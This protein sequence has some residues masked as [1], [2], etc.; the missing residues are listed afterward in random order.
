MTGRIEVNGEARPLAADNI[1]ALL[2]AERIDPRARGLAVALNGAVVP[3]RRWPETA[4][5]NGDRIEIVKP[6]AGG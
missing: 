4:I 5:S 6:F 3:R 2:R 1:Q